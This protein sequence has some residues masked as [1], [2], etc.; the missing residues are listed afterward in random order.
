MLYEV[1]T[2]ETVPAWTSEETETSIQNFMF[3]EENPK[4]FWVYP[5]YNFV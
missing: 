5:S 3:D 1:I 2:N 4:A